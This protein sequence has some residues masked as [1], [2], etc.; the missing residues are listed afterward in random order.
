MSAQHLANLSLES[1][2]QSQVAQ[3]PFLRLPVDIRRYFYTLVL[4]GPDAPTNAGGWTEASNIPKG[5]LGLLRVNKQIS[6]EAMRVLY[7]TSS[8]VTITSEVMAFREVYNDAK[9][10][11]PFKFKGMLQYMTNWQLA[12]RFNPEY[13]SDP[14]PCSMQAPHHNSRLAIGQYYIRESVFSIAVIL[15]EVSD[16]QNLKISFP[17]LCKKNEDTSVDRVREAISFALVPLRQLRFHTSVTFIAASPIDEPSKPM[18]RVKNASA[19]AANTQCQQPDCIAFVNSFDDI[20]TKLQ[21]DTPRTTITARQK[22]WMEL[23][24]I[25]AFMTPDTPEVLFALACVWFALDH[26][27]DEEFK[28]AVDGANWV[29]NSTFKDRWW[30]GWRR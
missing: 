5:F 20:K 1:N 15:A 9:F 14:M 17:C 19:S 22:E 3:F 24:L 6:D 7:G 10:F 25:A 13:N 18:D 26:K 12:L 28:W 8:T 11:L 2:E 23:K 4:R 29:I 16:L 21:D 30:P 27:T